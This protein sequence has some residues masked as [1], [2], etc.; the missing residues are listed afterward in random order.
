MNVLP[1]RVERLNQMAF[2]DFGD[3]ITPDVNTA[4]GINNGTCTRFHDL[5]QIDCSG[6]GGRT[7]LSLFRAQPR[8]LPLQIAM[9]ERHPLGTQAF[10]PRSTTPYLVVV[11]ESVE[12]KPRAFL[13]T[14][15]QGVNFRRGTWHHPLLALDVESE[16]VVIDRIG[17]GCNCDEVALAT[18]WRIDALPEVG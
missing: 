12:S 18:H 8:I 10:I 3:V 2:S 9:L 16:F 13:A 14:Q 5:A 7:G 1:L 11:A 17:P 4:L 6:E 15:G